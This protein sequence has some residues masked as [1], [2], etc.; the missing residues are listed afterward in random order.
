MTHQHR[1]TY[2]SIVGHPPLLNYMAIADGEATGRVK[3]ELTEVRT[4]RHFEFGIDAV[5]TRCIKPI[6]CE[7]ELFL[8]SSRSGCSS[9]AARRH[10]RR[11]TELAE[12]RS[13][14]GT[15]MMAW[16]EAGDSYLAL[17]L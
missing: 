13:E 5:A 1:D 8:S 3:F 2:S 16:P 11:T 17:A 6:V 14:E 10:P 12:W 15:G 9:R 7:P 4:L